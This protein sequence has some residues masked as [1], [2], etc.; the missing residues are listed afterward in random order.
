MG[1]RQNREHEKLWMESNWD[2]KRGGM[3]KKCEWKNKGFCLD[4]SAFFSQRVQ[5]VKILFLLNYKMH[6]KK[7][8]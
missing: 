4:N 8:K 5:S 2:Q 1:D 7:N 6:L 3:M